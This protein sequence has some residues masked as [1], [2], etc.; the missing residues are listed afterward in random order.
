MRRRHSPATILRRFRQRLHTLGE[1]L[2]HESLAL[3]HALDLDCDRL[4]RFFDTRESLLGH[5][6]DRRYARDAGHLLP[7]LER[8]PN[9][10]NHRGNRED[11]GNDYDFG[12]DHGSSG[13]GI[14][15]EGRGHRLYETPALE[16]PPDVESRSGVQARYG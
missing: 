12:F 14:G 7:V 8:H 6:I 15:P 11:S 2:R 4:E 3:A 10:E 1:Q 9:D 13:N 16:V 5:G